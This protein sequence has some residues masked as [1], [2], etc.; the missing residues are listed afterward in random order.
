[1]LLRTAEAKQALRT[2]LAANEEHKKVKEAAKL[3]AW[4]EDAYFQK[5]WR[6]VLDKQDRDRRERC[7]SPPRCVSLAS[8]RPG[9]CP[10]LGDGA[11]AL[12]APSRPWWTA[13][14][15]E[16]TMNRQAKTAAFVNSGALPEYKKWIDPA[17]TQRHF[18]EREEVREEV[19][20]GKLEWA[21]RQHHNNGR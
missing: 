16:K 18:N 12:V 21:K 13:R 3:A 5:A 10:W 7:A 4:E 8:R 20:P 19:V 1:M 9:P 17:I 14:R 2:F 6:E 15:L 11:R